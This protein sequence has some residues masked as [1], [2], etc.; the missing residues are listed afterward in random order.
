[1]RPS[2]AEAVVRADIQCR[3]ILLHGKQ[4][5][6]GINV[7]TQATIIADAWQVAGPILELVE[8]GER[9]RVKLLCLLRAGGALAAVWL[10]EGYV[11]SR[12]PVLRLRAWMNSGYGNVTW[13]QGEIGNSIH[14]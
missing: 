12:T 1:M 10:F 11:T 3:L 9:T 5:K 7:K 13:Y 14:S 6:P 2:N 4:G 8:L